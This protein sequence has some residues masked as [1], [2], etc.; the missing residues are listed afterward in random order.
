MARLLAALEQKKAEG[1]GGAGAPAVV[2]PEPDGS[3]PEATEA[4]AE[5][6]ADTAES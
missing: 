5:T 6:A 1:N 4:A 2:S 3:A